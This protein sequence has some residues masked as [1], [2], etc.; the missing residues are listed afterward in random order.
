MNWKEVLNT[1]T[2]KK[3]FEVLLEAGA[4]PETVFNTLKYDITNE[5]QQKELLDIIKNEQISDP[6]AMIMI[7]TEI[8]ERDNPEAYKI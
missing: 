7:A 1:E 5:T 3:V 6:N 8:D 2:S 4:E